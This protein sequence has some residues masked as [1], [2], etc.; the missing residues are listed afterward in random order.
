M[1]FLRWRAWAQVAV[2]AVALLL[3]GCGGRPTQPWE[4]LPPDDHFLAWDSHDFEIDSGLGEEITLKVLIHGSDLPS[5]MTVQLHLL[6]S[7]QSTDIAVLTSYAYRAGYPPYVATFR[8]SAPRD[9]SGRVLTGLFVLIACW[10]RDE[11]HRYC[12]ESTLLVT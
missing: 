3:P 7:G 9:P 5:A 6:P 4:T 10:A 1:G 2:W 11:T 8:V 12:T